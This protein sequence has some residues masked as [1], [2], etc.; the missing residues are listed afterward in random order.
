[1]FR[2]DSMS[3]LISGRPRPLVNL[4][5]RKPYH[6][7]SSRSRL[8]ISNETRHRATFKTSR[9]GEKGFERECSALVWSKG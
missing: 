8:L 3:Y 5:Y 4:T 9:Q 7:V 2:A 1:V 6:I